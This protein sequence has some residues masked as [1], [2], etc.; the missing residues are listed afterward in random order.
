MSDRPR[1]VL[2]LCTGNSARSILA[3]ALLDHWGKGRFRGFSAGSFPKGQVHPLALELLRSMNLPTENLRSKS[4][5]EFAAPAAPPIDFVVTVCD[6]AAAEA[7]PVWPGRPVTVHW[8][9]ADPAAA[10][11]EVQSRTAFRDVLADLEARIKMFVAQN[12]IVI[13]KAT[14]ADAAACVTIYRPFVEATA[15]SFETTVPTV[16]EF[17]S[18]IEN[19]LSAWT[20]L[21]AESDG[22]CIGYAYGHS[23][24]ARA[25]YRWSVEVTIYIEPGH[26]R[27]G[28]GRRLYQRL[29]DDL[30]NLGYC[31][32]YAGVTQPNEASMAL[33]RG[34]GFEYIGT[35]RA[36][37]R[38]FDRWH[39]VAWFQRKLREAPP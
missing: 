8:S 37:G 15:V 5:N 21:I 38:K 33:H 18:R 13:R 23:H 7:C 11:D 19:S 3:E 27:Q 10:H 31:N 17:A 4:W 32:V 12:G 24:R 16:E 39:D 26:R 35:F 28:L 29:F 34:V 22:R 36:V 25:A 9:V 14:T 30:T 2:F 6:N 1:H 20:W